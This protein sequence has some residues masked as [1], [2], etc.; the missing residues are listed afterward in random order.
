MLLTLPDRMEIVEVSPRDGL[1]GWKRQISVDDK[2]AM[3]GHLVAAGFTTIE[4]T[5]FAS[6]R[7]IPQFSDAEEL[8]ARLPR[9]AGVRYR[10]L[11]PNA[12]GAERAIAAGVDEVLGLITASATYLRKNQ[13][14]SMNEAV[15]QAIAGFEAAEKAVKPFVMAIGMAFWCA[16]EGTIPEER[17]M[18]LLRRF[19]QAGIRRFYLA[20]S[21]GLEDPVRV[22]R[23][24]AHAQDRF[25]DIELGFHVHD[26]AGRAAALTLAA[27]S[28]GARWIEGAIAGIGGG[29]AM[30]AGMTGV[31]N[32][33]T[34]DLVSLLVDSGI[35]CGLDP[36]AVTRASK[37]VADL[38]AIEPQSRAAH[39]ATRATISR[40]GAAAAM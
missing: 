14:M 5:G 32:Y 13:N 12:R 6:G 19:H 4:V 37:A 28:G 18:D 8:L 11:A 39:G 24:F 26:L 40:L 30:P 21:V 16:Y 1:Q 10:G 34:E 3:V 38:L 25:P 29:I 31:G 2:L 17:V 27:M 20:A 33:A 7:R 15:D 9:P 22:A 23:L 35:D 36:G